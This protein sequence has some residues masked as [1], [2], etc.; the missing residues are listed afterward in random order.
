MFVTCEENV[1]V[2]SFE[3]MYTVNSEQVGS[4]YTFLQEYTLLTPK[5]SQDSSFLECTF[6]V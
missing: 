5:E 2:S 4:S 6:N 1:R 3:Y